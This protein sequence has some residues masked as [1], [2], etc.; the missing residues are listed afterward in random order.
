MLTRRDVLLSGSALALC[1]CGPDASGKRLFL[2]S[3]SNSG[4]EHYA[5]AFDADG[6]LKFASPI[7]FRGHDIVPSPDGTSAV[8]VAR[9]PG[10]AVLRFDLADGYRLQS[11]GAAPDRHFYGHA[12]FTPDGKWF[13]T[14]END[15]EN[16]RGVIG[17]RDAKTLKLE[18]EIDSHGVGPHELGWLS[19]ARTLVVA[20]GGIQTHPDSGRDKLNLDSMQPSLVEIEWPS[21]RLLRS[22]QPKSVYTSIRHIDISGGDRVAIG[23][24]QEQYRDTDLPLLAVTA[25]TSDVRIPSMP[26]ADL[27]SMNQYVASVCIDR[28]SSN[29]MATCPRGHR[30]I[31]WNVGSG[32]FLGSYRLVDAAGVCVDE[33]AREFVVSTGRGFIH[34]FDTDTFEHRQEK[35]VRVPGL[36]WDNHLIAA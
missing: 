2:S 15:Y 5:A 26:D 30:L 36:R 34:R 1:G 20:N 25:P 32:Q 31:F 19:D 23:M 17:I 12:V 22:H 7:P 8:A 28:R 35:R 6:E 33:V 11:A 18:A 27:R 29:V 13:L 9:R 24:Q 3:A 16:G 4:S 14:T 21:G 10:T